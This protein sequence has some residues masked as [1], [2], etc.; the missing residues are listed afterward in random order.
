VKVKRLSQRKIKSSS[1]A[2]GGVVSPQPCSST[3]FI[4]VSCSSSSSHSPLA[5]CDQKSCRSEPGFNISHDQYLRGDLSLTITAADYSQRKVYA[6]ECEDSDFAYVRLVIETVFSAVQMEFHEDLKLHVSVPEPVEV[7]YKSSGSA[8]EVICRVNNLSLQCKD[9]YRDRTSLTY[10]EITLRHVEPRDSGSYTIRDTENEQDIQIYAVSVEGPGFPVW[11]IVLIVLIL[12]ICCCAAV[13]MYLLWK[14]LM[15]KQLDRRLQH[16]IQLAQQAEEGTEENIRAAEESFN[17]LEQQ[18]N[19]TEYSE[20]I[21][22][23]CTVKKTQLQQRKERLS[24]KEIIDLAPW[25]EFSLVAPAIGP[26]VMDQD[27]AIQALIVSG[28]RWGKHMLNR[29][30]LHMVQLVQQAEEGKQENTGEVEKELT[31][32]KNRYKDTEYSGKVSKFCMVQRTQLDWYRLQHEERHVT[33]KRELER[34]MLHVEQLVQK[35]KE[36]T[37]EEIRAAVEAIDELEQQYDD[38]V[39]S[40]QVSVLCVVKREH[41]KGHQ[42]S[43]EQCLITDDPEVLQKVEKLMI[44]LQKLRDR[45]ER[46]Q[47]IQNFRVMDEMQ[48]HLMEFKK[49]CD[50]RV[51][52]LISDNNDSDY[53]K[54]KNLAASCTDNSLLLNSSRTTE[55]YP[56]TLNLNLNLNL[57]LNFSKTKE[58][59]VDFST[60]QER[61]YQTP[62]INE[63]PVERLDSFRYLGV[64]ITQDLSWSFHIN[65]VVKKARQRLYHLR[66][67]RDFRLPSKVLRNF[68]SC[69][70]ESIL[71]GNI[72]TRFGNSTMQDRPALQR[73]V[74]SAERIIRTKLP[75]LH[76]IYSQQCWTKPRKIVK[77]LSHP[78]IEQ[79]NLLRDDITGCL[80][81]K[82]KAR[83]MQ[84][85]QFYSLHHCVLLFLILTFTTAPVSALDVCPTRVKLHHPVKLSCK[86]QCSGLLQWALYNNRDVV[87]AQCDQTSCRSEPGFN[88]S[89]DQYL[90]GDLSLTITAADYSQRN[91]Y[92]CECED[93]DFAYVRLVIETVFSAVQ[94]EFHE[95]L[96]LHVSVPE[97]VEVIYKSSGSADEVICR[98]NN[99]SLQCKDEYRDR[100][101]LTY[102]EI[103][104]R[105]VEPRDSG[106]YTIRDTENEQDIQIYAVSVEGPTTSSYLTVMV[107]QKGMS[108]LYFLRKLRSFNVCNKMLE[109]F[110]QSV[111]ASG[112]YSVVVCWGGSIS[113]RDASGINKLILK[114]G[115]IIGHKMETFESVRNRRSL[116]KLLSIMDDPSHK[117]YN[118]LQNKPGLPVWGIVLIFLSLPCCCVGV[119]IY[120]LRRKKAALERRLEQV[121]QLVRQAVGGTE[122]NINEAEMSVDQLKQQYIKTK[123]SD[124]VKLFCTEKRKQLQQHRED[125][126]GEELERQQRHVEQLVHQAEEGTKEKMREAEES[127]DQ[128]KQQYEDTEYSDKVSVF[129]RAKRKQLVNSQLL[130]VEQLVQQAEEGKED[131]IREA[132]EQINQL[133]QQYSEYSLRVSAF[134]SAKR[135]QLNWYRLQHSNDEHLMTEKKQLY[136]QQQQVEQFVQQAEDGKVEKIREAKVE[137]DHLEQMQYLNTENV[138]PVTPFSMLMRAKLYWRSPKEYNIMELVEHGGSCRKPD[139]N[140]VPDPLAVSSRIPARLG[141]TGCPST[142]MQFYSLHHCVLLFLILTFTTAMQFYSLHHCVLLFL[143]LTFTTGSLPGGACPEHL[144]REMSRRHPKQMP[145]PPQL[146]PFNVEEQRLY[147]ELFPG[148]RDPYPISEGAPRH[149]MEKL[150]SATC[151]KDTTI[152]PVSALDV[153]PTR[154]KLHQ[155]VKLSCKHQCSGLLQWNLFSDRDVVLAQCDQKSCRSEPGFSISHDQYLRG[156]LSLTITAADY[157]QRNMYACECGDIDFSYARLVIETVFS[158][159]QMEFHEDLKLHV[160]VPEPVE[161]IYKSSGSA[162]EVICR[163]N[164]LSLQCKDEYRDRTSL[165][166]PEITLRHVEPRDSGSYTIRDTE[167]DQDIQIYAVSVEEP[168]VPAWGIVLIVMSLICC[169]AV[170]MYLLW[171]H[172]MGKQLNRRLLRVEVLVQHAEEG[173]EETIRE[174]ERALDQLEE[175]YENTE[176]SEQIS[177]I[178]E[179]KRIQIQQLREYL[180]SEE[181]ERKLEYLEQRV[182]QVLEEQDISEVEMELDQLDQQYNNSDYSEK[183][184]LFCMKKREHLLERRKQLVDQFVQQAVGG[185]EEKVS[186]V[187]K[188]LRQLKEQYINTEY[189]YI[190]KLFCMEKGKQLWDMRVEHVEQ[191]VK[192]AKVGKEENI[193]EVEMALSQ[194]ELKY[195]NTE[196]AEKMEL[197]CNASRL[198]LQRRGKC[199]RREGEGT[200]RADRQRDSWRGNC[201]MW[202]ILHSS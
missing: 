165:T 18:Y 75:D 89:H 125:L 106:S 4:T 113:A 190:V 124:K 154:T 169:A 109:I 121:E 81:T 90:G 8:D 73:V 85:M 86:H 184:K 157:S 95:D 101:S 68:Y 52:G 29:Q 31:Q 27:L 53:R 200:T 140:Q 49:W 37:E 65:T 186:E 134:C 104:L 40:Q 47:E 195:K 201:Y 127:L 178:N 19:T 98:V 44:S 94:M 55:H 136:R 110:Y 28:L 33:E 62:V 153:C 132:E 116:N 60:K 111:V 202:N 112:I 103:T 180:K 9:E 149:P 12:L 192:L 88:I 58:L 24:R 148:D 11:G 191:L 77:D 182:Q 161:V 5:Q 23:L 63:S 167:N 144:P 143:I 66:R 43:V 39:Y 142:T 67:L 108:R 160:S 138:A 130:Q 50:I 118:T 162:D 91:V 164:N 25:I 152:A 61:N 99:L 64:H 198:H 139:R 193:S 117:L 20:Q 16:V 71:T 21:S 42:H 10:P 46:E 76:S 105:H 122:E 102:P 32:L 188:S 7:I 187:E 145:E 133:E 128:L 175:K 170:G 13:G 41:L 137:I 176:Y 38:T 22:M 78:N 56:L 141:H 183:V 59:I 70:I 26:S 114:A 131:N 107:N 172:L 69:T 151:I 171:K 36:G 158:P 17:Q 199:L 57:L 166:Y 2:D 173:T 15:R 6:C 189:S 177:M 79:F 196:Y 179:A 54:V 174:A 34:R 123:Y 181:L 14:H 83:Q 1:S 96:K 74:R 150:I 119:G 126:M 120:L 197:F 146:A 115:S 92:A 45:A 156:D 168:G 82:V 3:A 159:V 97:P 185:T 100:T 35:A 129:C 80:E 84:T 163:V 51:I 30:L 194:L 72:T 87:Q 135:K 48:K 147:S 93:S 155:P